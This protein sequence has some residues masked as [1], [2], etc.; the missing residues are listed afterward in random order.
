M[1]T[2][3][4][5]PANKSLRELRKTPFVL[6]P[7]DVVT[8]P[9]KQLRSEN[10]MTGTTQTFVRKG[11]RASL[12]LVLRDTLDRPRDGVDFEVSVDGGPPITGT[13]KSDGIVQAPVMANAK[14]ATLTLH[15]GVVPQRYQLALGNLDPVDTI[16]GQQG[17]LGNLGYWSGPIDGNDTPE[18]HDALAVFQ[19]E[20]GLEPSGV[21]DSTTCDKL[22]EVHGS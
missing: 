14:Q 1:N 3:W 5:D 19:D 10:G 18:L 17:R 7:G 16:A 11:L 9:D 15:L 21:A 13:T 8:L 2:I 20:L 4:D 6:D 22:V 12:Q